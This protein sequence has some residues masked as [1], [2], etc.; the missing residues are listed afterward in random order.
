[1]FKKITGAVVALLLVV[2][3]ASCVNVNSKVKEPGMVKELY[4]P[5][6]IYMVSDSVN[7]NDFTSDTSS[8]CFKRSVQ[9]DNIALF[10]HKEYGNDP[11]L[12]P[13]TTKRFSPQRALEE[14]GRFYNYYVNELKMVQKGNSLSDKYKLLIF[15]FGGDE[16]T[17]FGGGSE[18]KV[19]ILWTPAVRIH[20]EPFGALAHEMAHSF[21]YLSSADYG[22]GPR[23]PIMEMSAQYMLWQVY[24]E[25]MTFE[26]YHLDAFLT[27]THFAFLHPQN[28]YHSPYVLEYW[29]EKHGKDFYGKLSRETQEGEDPVATYKRI[30]GITQEQ[31]NDEIFDASRRFITW[32]LARVEEVAEPY[33]NMHKTQLV[34]EGK[35]WYS[36]DSVN[37]P[38]NYGYNGIQLEVPEAGT[39]IELDFRGMANANG[40]TNVKVDKA[41]WRYGFVAYLK[42]GKRV[43]SEMYKDERGKVSFKVPEQTAFLWF[44]VSGAPKEHWPIVFNWGAP[45]T[46]D[47]KEEQWA[48][49]FHLKGAGVKKVTI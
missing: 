25:W 17:A 15:V 27:K 30:T 45:K 10:W 2:L 6:D 3:A 11:M 22:T 9:S 14:C 35:G 26:K 49:K 7:Q 8:Y 21:Q 1:M 29:S 42:N 48:Y 16:G 40:Y 34:D 44:V 41:G 23:G 19:G 36:I 13:D 47:P 28:M 37:C 38:Q 43:Y 18:D 20:K 5:D 32:D 24:P 4:L 39:Q 12:N 46:D 31:F 33:K